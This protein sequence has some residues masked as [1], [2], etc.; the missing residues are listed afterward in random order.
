MEKAPGDASCGAPAHPRWRSACR[1]GS[2]TRRRHSPARPCGSSRN[3]GFSFLDSVAAAP[4]RLGH[5]RLDSHGVLYIFY[6]REMSVDCC[7]RISSS[8]RFSSCGVSQRVLHYGIYCCKTSSLPGMPEG[9]R[10]WLLARFAR[11]RIGRGLSSDF[12]PYF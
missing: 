7:A 9:A 1:P 12:V 11:S 10:A 8:R 2:A 3:K 5:P 4:R 6:G